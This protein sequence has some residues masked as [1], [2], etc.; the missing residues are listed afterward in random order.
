M[1]DISLI[2]NTTMSVQQNELIRDTVKKERGRLLDFIRKRVS[3]EEDAEDIL[4]DVFFELVETYRLMKPVEKVASWLFTVARNKI[5]DRY[6]KKKTLSL[7]NQL[8]FGSEEEGERLNFEELLEDYSE[9]ADS[10]LIRNIIVEALDEAM[11]ELP[12]EQREVFIMHEIEDRSFQE[13]SELT[14][15]SVNTLLS[16]KRYAVLHLRKRLK[17]VYKEFSKY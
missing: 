2:L 9:S 15:V 6:R 10:E 12:E 8:G 13:I 17:S 16:R 3:S 5:T 4:Q 1:E 7:E 14:G 11:E